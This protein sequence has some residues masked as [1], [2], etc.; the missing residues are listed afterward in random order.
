MKKILALIILGN[1]FIGFL[2][3]ITH[4]KNNDNY[5]IVT[6][7]Y[8]PLPNQKYYL[9]GNYND[10]KTL[11]G[12]WIIGASWK[13]VFS[14]M[15]AAPWKYS[16][17]TK[18]YL[19]WLGIWEVSDRGGAIV[20]AGKRW[21]EHDRIDVWV[22]YGDEWLRRALYW[23]KRKIKGSV[24]KS[25]SK[26]TLNYKTI[27]SP[28]WA[29]KNMKKI[30]N[31][32]HTPLGIGGDKNK[33]KELQKFFTEIGLYTWKI[34]GK[35]NNEI[36]DIVYNFQLKNGIFKSEYDYGAWYWWASTRNLFLKKYINGD[37]TQEK[38]KSLKKSEILT[39]FDSPLKNKNSIKKLQEILKKLALYTWEI[40]GKYNSIRE[41]ILNYQLNRE[42][43]AS[44]KSIW[45]GIF[46]PKT[47][48]SLKKEYELYLKKEKRELELEKLFD[49]TEEESRGI[50]QEKIKNIWTPHYRDIS[51][52]VRSLQKILKKVWY[53]NY[54]D[55]AIFGPKTRSSIIAFQID[56][57]IIENSSQLWAGIF[58]P[59]TKKALE[60]ELTNIILQEKLIKAGIFEE[61]QIM[62]NSKK[63]D[64][65]KNNISTKKD[66]I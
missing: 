12:Q 11:N 31:I 38:I 21:Y 35:Y 32:F 64:K 20:K 16:F 29:T 45:A 40:D 55:T 6:A 8:S 44:K 57:W 4:A 15:L 24:V 42:I 14:G 19:K 3:K 48:A 27:P 62:R 59:K 53:F 17:W 46:W 26:I 33:V 63:E 30:S 23:G 7:Y 5:F 39:L 47:R 56:M 52:N 49:E 10:E 58:W 41:D 13:S 51:I 36:I 43:V 60:K 9:K 25:N 61:I 34:T 28:L 37:F 22:W 18:I 65:E 50:A 2:P 1:I 54:R 66:T